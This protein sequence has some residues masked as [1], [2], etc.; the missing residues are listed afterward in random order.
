MGFECI[1]IN[2]RLPRARSRRSVE[3]V[4]S[5]PAPFVSAGEE[6]QTGT[7]GWMAIIGGRAAATEQQSFAFLV[8]KAVVSLS[9]DPTL[10]VPQRV[11]PG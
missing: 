2:N 11:Q 5:P 6:S 3:S 9:P 7:Q 10:T 1:S 8:L 4:F